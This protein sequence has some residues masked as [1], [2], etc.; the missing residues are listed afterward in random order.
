MTGTYFELRTK[1]GEVV[2]VGE[3]TP[4][5]GV[6]LRYPGGAYSGLHYRSVGACYEALCGKRNS[7]LWKTVK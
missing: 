1:A 3:P 5:G 6:T 7:Y 4:N 2:Y